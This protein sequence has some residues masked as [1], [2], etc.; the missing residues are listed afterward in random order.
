MSMFKK[1]FARM[2]SL[3]L[4]SID[5]NFFGTKKCPLACFLSQK[6]IE[7]DIN[8]ACPNKSSIYTVTNDLKEASRDP[9]IVMTIIDIVNNMEI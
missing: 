4:E 1:T 7:Q 6:S 2:F 8:L 9:E 5:Y 3:I